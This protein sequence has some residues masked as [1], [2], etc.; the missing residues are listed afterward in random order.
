MYRSIPDLRLTAV[1]A[2]GVL[3]T[4]LVPLTVPADGGPAAT[5]R[6]LEEGLQR[7][8]DRDPGLFAALVIPSNG[9]VLIPLLLLGVLLYAR[10]G[11]LFAAGFLLVA[12]ELA[13][14]INTWALKPLW[15]RQLHDYLAYPSGHTVQFVAIATAFV[16]VA[17][18]GRTR[19]AV[20]VVAAVVLVPVGAGMVGL[21][22]HH[23]TD[24]VGGAGAAVALVTAM[25][26]G[27]DRL[28]RH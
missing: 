3:V 21:G 26:A 9:Y 1:V 14:A 22:Y 18:D 19:I 17:A 20:G 23:P 13:V 12:P 11:N 15:H 6:V 25:Y 5:D 24:I 10:G 28:R 8:G 2:V 16:L 4:V 27:A 7:A